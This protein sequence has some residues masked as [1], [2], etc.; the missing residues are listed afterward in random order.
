MDH[1]CVSGQRGRQERVRERKLY[2]R[3]TLHTRKKKEGLSHTQF[4][5]QKQRPLAV[6]AS[7]L[8][9]KYVLIK[10]RGNQSCL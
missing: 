4:V 9:T 2:M 8:S 7:V 10:E 1:A 3:D 6:Q 5:S